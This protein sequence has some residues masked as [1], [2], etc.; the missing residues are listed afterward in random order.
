MS[1]ESDESDSPLESTENLPA[2]PVY[3]LLKYSSYLPKQNS[4]VHHACCLQKSGQASP[5]I[6]L[7]SPTSLGPPSPKG[8]EVIDE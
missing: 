8:T 7:G 2:D 5:T 1:N 3:S 4:A 6:S